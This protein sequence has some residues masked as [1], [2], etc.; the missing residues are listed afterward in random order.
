MNRLEGRVAVVTGAARGIGRAIA[1]AYAREGARV[2]GVDLDTDGVAEAI[3][4]IEALGS[5][6]LARTAD[7]ADL[8]AMQSIIEEA[9]RELGRLDILVNNV[10][11]FEPEITNSDTDVVRTPITSWDRIYDVNIRAVFLACKVAIP[12]MLESAGAGNIV[13]VSSTS[14]FHGDVNYVAYSS[15]KAAMH[16][17]TRSI[18]TSHGRF[19]IRANC[20]ATGL[21]LTETAKRNVSADMLEV[22]RRHRLVPEV[23]SPDD[24]APLAVFLASD[25]SRSLIGQTIVIDGGTSSVHQP[26]YVD[27]AVL[28]PDLVGSNFN[29]P[30]A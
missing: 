10:A 29:H 13:N 11:T 3:A 2:V 4:E 22:W 9:A 15:T 18:A 14:G 19:G 28:H 26:W 12:L 8:D 24:I 6:G 16:A 5:G 17:L 21:V 25:E 27:S 23:G 20:I 7:V 1:V 30:T